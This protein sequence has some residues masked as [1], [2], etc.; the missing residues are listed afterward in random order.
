MLCTTHTHT[1]TRHQ[2][3]FYSSASLSRYPQNLDLTAPLMPTL[4]DPLGCL[5]QEGECG[6]A[7]SKE[8]TGKE[9]RRRDTQGKDRILVKL[10][11]NVAAGLPSPLTLPHSTKHL[12][13]H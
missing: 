8:A 3:S 10:Q 9:L 6:Q 11:R 13:G 12:L 1:L 7:P 2:T 5:W 4:G